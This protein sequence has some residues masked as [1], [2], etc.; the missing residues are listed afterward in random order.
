MDLQAVE[1]LHERLTLLARTE[2]PARVATLSTE[3]L[4]ML[5]QRPISPGVS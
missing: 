5:R 1:A 2:E 3:L 4:E